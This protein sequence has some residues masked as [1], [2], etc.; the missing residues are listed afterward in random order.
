M[1]ANHFYTLA[2]KDGEILLASE[3]QIPNFPML[4]RATIEEVGTNLYDVSD[5]MRINNGLRRI[6]AAN[7]YNIDTG[8]EKAPDES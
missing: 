6:Q 8:S 1:N 4:V 5:F 2:S 7:Y 3:H